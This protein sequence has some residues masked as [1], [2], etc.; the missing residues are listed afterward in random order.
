MYRSNTGGSKRSV[1]MSVKELYFSTIFGVHKY[2]SFAPMTSPVLTSN[3]NISEIDYLYSLTAKTF[4][5]FWLNGCYCLE[6][7]KIFLELYE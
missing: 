3:L 4:I 7:W 6:F 2:N 5:D 1:V